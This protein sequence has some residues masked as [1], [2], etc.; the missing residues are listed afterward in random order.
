M[1]V[2]LFD[3]RT[4]ADA[5]VQDLVNAGCDVSAIGVLT[6]DD[7]PAPDAGGATAA[8]VG[9]GAALGGLWG[10]LVGLGVLV[11]PGVGPVLAAGPLAG[12]LAGASLGAATGGVIGILVEVG[13]SEEDAGRYAEA[14]RR[15]AV[16]VTVSG[17]DAETDR[18]RAILSRHA[19]VDIEAR[20]A[21]W[22]GAGWTGFDATAPAWTTEDLRRE[23][24]RRRGRAA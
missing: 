11:I 13:L 9:A 19:P 12:A 17:H 6:A 8:G 16:L 7:R 14:L 3:D 22:R 10:L 18:L 21:E 4:T 15:G 2:A 23:R 5:A 20:A 1:I 24:E